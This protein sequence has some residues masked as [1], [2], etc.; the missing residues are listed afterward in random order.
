MGDDDKLNPEDAR[1]LF[2]AFALIGLVMGGKGEDPAE[3]VKLAFH[4]GDLAAKQL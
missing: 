1:L 2:A 4:Y 3:H